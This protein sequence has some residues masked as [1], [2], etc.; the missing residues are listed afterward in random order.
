MIQQAAAAATRIRTI[1]DQRG[2][3]LTLGGEPTYVPLDPVGDEWSITALGPTKLPKARAFCREVM[4]SHFNGAFSILTPGKLYPGETNPRWVLHAVKARDGAPMLPDETRPQRDAV[5]SDPDNLL[6]H[7]LLN[8]GLENSVL[9]KLSDPTERASVVRVLP[10]DQD[11][12]G[13]WI[14]EQWPLEDDDLVLGGADGGAGLRLPLGLLPETAIRRAL[15]VELRNDRLVIFMPPLLQE[16]F[17]DLLGIIGA[18]LTAEGLPAFEIEGYLPSDEAEIWERI[19]F[20]ADPGVLEINL[21]PCADWNAY[22]TWLRVLHECAATCGMR[23]AK[24]GVRGGLEGSG[25]GNHLLFGGPSHELNPFFTRPAWLVGICRFFQRHP[26]LA[27]AFTGKFVGASS[28]APRPDETELPPA[29]LELAY[30]TLENLEPGD[31]RQVISETLRHLHADTSG[32]AHCSE[33][34]FDKFWVPGT[35]GG[36]AGLI[37][38]RAIEAMPN[39]EWNSWIALLWLGIAAA[40]LEKPNTKTVTRWDGALHDSMLLPTHIAADLQSVLDEV[41]EAGIDLRQGPWQE[42]LDWRFPRL[43][44]DTTS[45]IEIRLAPEVWPLLSDYPTV[46]GGTSRFVDSS[47]LRLDISV[48]T[49]SAS[50]LQIAIAGHLLP[51]KPGPCGRSLA[52]LRFRTS[53]LFPCL[54]PSLPV[55]LPLRIDIWTTDGAACGS[56]ILETADGLFEASESPA[57]KPTAHLSV[58]KDQITCDLR[59]VQSK[60]VIL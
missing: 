3:H 29:E 39:H 37:E 54:H 17:I 42:I 44:A 52:G 2:I 46:G 41:A 58:P 34:S 33:I 21:P 27:Y 14:S 10:L 57:S 9:H 4:R 11:S 45:G 55:Q 50:T 26:S 23:S 24:P 16:A 60:A 43:L 12:E 38:F 35:P 13:N 31:H 47:M 5:E 15:T 56:W 20:A 8:M 49:E 6:G 51:L 36:C 19:G 18:A 53:A 59:Q 25:G 48:P 1:L 40:V 32:S 22:A 30:H 7:L 28:Q